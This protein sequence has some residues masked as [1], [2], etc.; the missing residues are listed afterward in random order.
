MHEFF[1]CSHGILTCHNFNNSLLISGDHRYKEAQSSNFG[2]CVVKVSSQFCWHSSHYHQK[3]QAQYKQL[4][5]LRDAIPSDCDEDIVDF[6]KEIF[7]HLNLHDDEDE[8]PLFAGF[9]HSFKQKLDSLRR[10]LSFF[11]SPSFHALFQRRRWSNWAQSTIHSYTSHFRWK[12]PSRTVPTIDKSKIESRSYALS[13]AFI[14]PLIT[15][16][17][18]PTIEQEVRNFWRN[19]P[20]IFSAKKTKWIPPI[21]LL[22]ALFEI[23]VPA[24]DDLEVSPTTATTFEV[25]IC[26][27][28][29]QKLTWN[30]QR[31]FIDFLKLH[32]LL[33]LRQFQGHVGVLPPFP[34]HVAYAFKEHHVSWSSKS[35][36]MPSTPS[37][38]AIARRAALESY[39][40]ALAKVLHLKPSSIVEFAEFLEISSFTL[41]GL[42]ATNVKTKDK[43]GYLKVNTRDTIDASIGASSSMGGVFSW[44]PRFFSKFSSWPLFAGER[45]WVHIS[46]S[47]R[48]LVILEDITSRTP[49]RVLF[50]D[51][52]EASSFSFERVQIGTLSIKPSSFSSASLVSFTAWNTRHQFSAIVA[53]APFS[54]WI[55]SF[56][57]L[58]LP[59]KQDA[60]FSKQHV[61][62][63]IDAASY[64][65]SLA[66]VLESAQKEIFIMG[67]WLSPELY[68]KRPA[69]KYP[70]S[71][72]DLLLKRKAD[73]GVL[74][75]ILIFKEWS[76]ALYLNSRHTKEAL[77]TLSPRIMVQRHPDHL[78]PSY[79][80]HHEKLVIVDGKV[81][82]LGGI[83]L[84][85][86]R[87]DDQ[88]HLLSESKFLSSRFEG[89]SSASLLLDEKKPI[90]SIE[91]TSWSFSSLFIA[92][93]KENPVLKASMPNGLASPGCLLDR[94]E[95]T[96]WV[97]QDYYNPR[98]CDFRNVHRHMATL[99]DR[100]RVPRMPWH[101]VHLQLEG[102]TVPLLLHRFF[103]E[104][105]NFVKW[106]K[107][108][109]RSDELPWLLPLAKGPADPALG[110]C[111]VSLLL[112]RGAWSAGT[113][114]PD[115][116]ILDAYLN[117][118]E[119][120]QSYIYIENQFFISSCVENPYAEPWEQ[121]MAE[122]QPINRIAA[123][124]ARRIEKAHFGGDSSFRVIIV[125]P[126]LPA[127]EFD[128]YMN[129]A[130]SFRIILNAQ[131]KTMRALRERLASLNIPIDKHL[132]IF[133]L[134]TTGFLGEDRVCEQIYVH[135]KVFI[136]DDRKAIVG[137]PNINDR[138]MLGFRDSEIALLIEDEHRVK[139]LF[140][141]LLSEHLGEH[142]SSITL[143]DDFF[144]HQILRATAEK[145]TLFYRSH[146][147][148]LPDDTVT[149]WSE[150]KAF[151]ERQQA[152][153]KSPTDEG[154]IVKGA[155]VFFPVNFLASEDL[156][157][158]SWRSPEYLLP[159]EVFS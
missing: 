27:G 77:E 59:S 124:I 100:S 43:E 152:L 103:C 95:S 146:F 53:G 21:P 72:L 46:C 5:N 64:F 26:Y 114:M 86:G 107:S 142:F 12:K 110:T 9:T 140:V 84:C 7:A 35:G 143:N 137:S 80:A 15:F 157:A 40:Q 54:Q 104:R 125:T 70:E 78:P 71:R 50:I 68:L 83:D 25:K 17:H 96:N 37:S 92:T 117:L 23:T 159:F 24:S 138:S 39:L 150:Y 1:T 63:F 41:L 32:A 132:S 87:Y 20:W 94:S 89:S 130:A 82:F 113:L 120:S 49:L 112:S 85:F 144:Y 28:D 31:R 76:F 18:T 60:L 29:K 19:W 33:T 133:A 158:I 102:S 4:Q 73:S 36:N 122:P 98:F 2:L 123:A 139:E 129:S 97:G 66:D 79:W 126:L 136:V 135:S 74:I 8:S 116:S 101:D 11:Q 61:N 141:G 10:S 99:V 3:V 52:Q 151:V 16:S 121:G 65:S 119:E 75:Y 106:T 109:H 13:A 44:V 91:Q 6:N 148:A 38:F 51:N 81:A 14:L 56:A 134:R 145:N 67:W 30:I 22:S 154:N 147:S 131:L 105:W 62:W 118:I 48:V 90:A 34:F 58:A 88:N 69:E 57:R 156:S 149:T 42:K 127:F 111:K 128:L 93:G 55:P 153:L 108:M 47:D 115:H 155:L 45:R